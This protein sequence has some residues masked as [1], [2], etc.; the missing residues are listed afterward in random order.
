MSDELNAAK[1]K[2]AELEERLENATTTRKG[3][4]IERQ[5]AVFERRVE[6]LEASKPKPKENNENAEERGNQCPNCGGEL[7]DIGD[8]ILQCQVCGEEWEDE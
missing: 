2:I 6:A 8:D 3:D 7:I 1:I 5:L 4:V